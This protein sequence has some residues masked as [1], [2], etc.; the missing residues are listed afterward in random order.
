MA[1]SATRTESVRMYVISPTGPSAPTSMPS[2]SCCAIRIVTAAEKPSCFAASCCSVLVR[3]GGG[4]ARRRSPFSTDVTL[5][6]S[7]SASA[8]IPRAVGGEEHALRGL[9]GALDL[10]ER[11]RLF[12]D[13][14]VL[15]REAVLHVHAELALR[16][17]AQVPHGR[18]DR[19]ACAQVLTDRLG[20]GGGL[21][22]DERALPAPGTGRL[23]L[24]RPPLGSIGHGHRGL[25]L[26][27]DQRAFALPGLAPGVSL[28]P[29]HSCVLTSHVSILRQTTRERIFTIRHSIAQA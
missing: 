6:G 23:G 19:V 9:R 12:L 16:Q 18:L 29:F 28:L 24:P 4:A 10:G 1:E 15:G 2:Y 13:R 7:F 26:S 27:R 20:L 22:D 17:I 3:K 25:R 14:H 5:K 21:D 11:F 8:T